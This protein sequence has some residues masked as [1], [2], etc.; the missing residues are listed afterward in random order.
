MIGTFFT[1]VVTLDLTLHLP[2][3][4]DFW[5]GILLDSQN[6][7]GNPMIKHI[8]LSKKK[9]LEKKHF[10]RW[11]S[12]WS[13][14]IDELFCGTIADQAKEKAAQIATLMLYKIDNDGTLRIR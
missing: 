11:L 3:I 7:Q 2:R 1:T 10:D 13:A 5:A 14:T 8:E 6:Y 12:I 9:K 4:I